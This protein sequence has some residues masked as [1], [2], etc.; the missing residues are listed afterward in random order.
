MV[1]LP[2]RKEWNFHCGSMH[3]KLQNYPQ[4]SRPVIFHNAFS[5][6][7][8]W[9][10]NPTTAT[11]KSNISV[12]SCLTCFTLQMNHRDASVLLSSLKKC[13]QAF[14]VAIILGDLENNGGKCFQS[15]FRLREIDNS[16]QSEMTERWGFFERW[17]VKY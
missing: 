16:K 1:S 9:S 11:I 2:S 5:F 7:I 6:H 8:L 4:F 15:I 17:P 12:F 3:H 13:Q 10:N 14:G